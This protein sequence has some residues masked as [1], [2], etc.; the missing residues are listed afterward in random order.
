MELLTL[1]FVTALGNTG[2]PFI[3]DAYQALKKKAF[4]KFGKHRDFVDSVEQ[5]EKNPDSEGR[6]KVLEEEIVKHGIDKDPELVE[7]A[8]R[9]LEQAK[10]EG[11]NTQN[12][13][14]SNHIFSQFGNV[15]VNKGKD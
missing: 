8:N 13:Q 2:N 11:G 4:T 6:Q 15:T 5:L 3:N 14:G 7:A 9:I 12:V 10:P 1:A